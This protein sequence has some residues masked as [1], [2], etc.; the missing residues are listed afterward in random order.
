MGRWISLPWRFVFSLLVCSILLT[1]CG[2]GCG[3]N[4]QPPGTPTSASQATAKQEALDLIPISSTIVATMDWQ[5]TLE[6]PWGGDV[7]S[8]IPEDLTS[9]I[10]DIKTVRFAFRLNDQQ[11]LK[12][13]L[14]IVSGSLD[15]N[16]IRQAMLQNAEAAQLEDYAGVKIYSE[17]KGQDNS[18]AILPNY[19]L[20]GNKEILKKAIDL[21]Q[22][23]GS[24]IRQNSVLMKQIQRYPGGKWLAVFG[25]WNNKIAASA[26]E[27]LLPEQSHIHSFDLVLDHG[28]GLSANLGLVM[29]SS[30]EATQLYQKLNTLK[31]LLQTQ[32]TGQDAKVKQLVQ[33]LQIQN[34]DERVDLA[35]SI[36]QA[37][38]QGLTQGMYENPSEQENV[39]EEGDFDSPSFNSGNFNRGNTVARRPRSSSSGSSAAGQYQY[40]FRPQYRYVPPPLP[41]SV[42]Q[43]RRHWDRPGL[44]Y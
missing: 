39:A 28:E 42:M 31:Q 8:S 4:E 3:Q 2:R 27:Q 6:S 32:L 19:L 20:F 7:V 11:E 13:P 41:A 22:G 16:S 43:I 23:R 34:S 15:L 30:G 21:S 37:T 25:T 24:S 1:H 14:A 10:D 36:D 40:M 38:F 35:L 44:K 18:I 5:K 12:D 9:Y 26:L 29:K 33:S 17:T